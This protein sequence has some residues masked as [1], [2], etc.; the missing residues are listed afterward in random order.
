[1]YAA[2]AKRLVSRDPKIDKLAYVLI[3]SLELLNAVMADVQLLQVLKVLKTFQFLYAIR[4]YRED[5]ELRKS[6]EVL[7]WQ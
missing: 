7:R 5:L 4:L 3:E 6:P 2:S 1:M